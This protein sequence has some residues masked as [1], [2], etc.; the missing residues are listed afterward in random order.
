ML[1]KI[2]VAYE[3]IVLLSANVVAFGYH[4]AFEQNFG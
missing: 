3:P 1:T 4:V 2:P